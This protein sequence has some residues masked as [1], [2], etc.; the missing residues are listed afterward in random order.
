VE[1]KVST[2]YGQI[3]GEKIY[4]KQ[5]SFAHV[6]YLNLTILLPIRNNDKI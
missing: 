6:G 4:T 2:K 5:K 1:K 3:D